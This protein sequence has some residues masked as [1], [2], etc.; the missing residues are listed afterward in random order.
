M[1]SRTIGAVVILVNKC[2]RL[3][4]H[5]QIGTLSRQRVL[6]CRSKVTNKLPR[7]RAG[8][9]ISQRIDRRHDTARCWPWAGAALPSSVPINFRRFPQLSHPHSIKDSLLF[10]KRI[11]G[12]PL[13]DIS[14]VQ[15]KDLICS[16]DRRK[17]VRNHQ[18]RFA[19]AE[20]VQLSLNSALGGIV[21]SGGGLVQ[22]KNLGIPQDGSGDRHSLLLALKDNKLSAIEFKI[23]KTPSHPYQPQTT[24]GHALQPRSRIPSQ[25]T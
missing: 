14:L 19:I 16:H 20:R 11:K 3:F 4:G 18:R 12:A 6:F 22:E 24:E 8:A 5:K 9:L 2:I 1:D 21:Q 10:H 7:H 23:G 25:M 13:D 15:D 17:T